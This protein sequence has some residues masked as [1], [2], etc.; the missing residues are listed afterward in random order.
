MSSKA[1]FSMRASPKEWLRPL[2]N[3]TRAFSLTP[4]ALLN[5]FWCCC[6]CCCCCWW[7]WNN[8]KWKK[9]WHRKPGSSDIGSWLNLGIFEIKVVKIYLCWL[10]LGFRDTVKNA[11][12][13]QEGEFVNHFISQLQNEWLN[14]QKIDF[15]SPIIQSYLLKGRRTAGDTDVLLPHKFLD[16]TLQAQRDEND[17]RTIDRDPLQAIFGQQILKRQLQFGLVSQR[18]LQLSGRKTWVGN[19]SETKSLSCFSPGQ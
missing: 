9:C 15:L 7:C 12:F 18:V 16:H 8:K 5:K 3:R 10:F 19:L 2:R 11:V 1:W 14:E 13:T 4:N 17:L 6:C